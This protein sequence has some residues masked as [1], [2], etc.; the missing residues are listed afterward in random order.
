M[1]VKLCYHCLFKMRKTAVLE[2][3]NVRIFFI[4]LN[5]LTVFY[6]KF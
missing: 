6:S 1:I 3:E 4:I 2:S 5:N